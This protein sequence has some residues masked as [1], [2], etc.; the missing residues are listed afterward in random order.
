MLWFPVRVCSGTCMVSPDSCCSNIRDK[1]RTSRS[2]SG[3]YCILYY[4]VIC[5]NPAQRCSLASR[6]PQHV[7]ARLCTCKTLCMR[8]TVHQNSS[9]QCHA[10]KGSKTSARIS[11][12]RNKWP[13]AG[14]ISLPLTSFIKYAAYD[15]DSAARQQVFEHG[16]SETI[17]ERRAR[18]D[19]AHVTPSRRSPRRSISGEFSSP[20]STREIGFGL[21]PL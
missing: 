9:E 14:K 17:I 8:I 11:A 12:D 3:L 6:S 21:W 13:L 7:R 15:G 20:A 16:Q 18:S 10:T 1:E 19:D 5:R 2:H 4:Y